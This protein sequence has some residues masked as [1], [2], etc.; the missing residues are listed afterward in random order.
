M[1]LIVKGLS[2]SIGKQE[3]FIDE[4]FG[5][6]D[7][8]KVGI[9]GRNGVGKTT[10]L[11][12]IMGNIDYNGT[13]TCQGRIAYFAQHID[14]DINLTVLEELNKGFDSKAIEEELKSIE[15]QMVDPKINENL[16]KITKITER[17]SEL[18]ARLQ[19][20]TE[21]KY[22][23][24]VQEVLKTLRID[25]SFARKKVSELS[26]GQKAILSLAK[27]FCSKCDILLLDE[28]TNH[29]D[30]ERLGILE[31]YISRFKGTILIITHDRFLLDKVADTILKI[32]NGHIIKFPGNY[33]AYV[34]QRKMLFEAQL[35]SFENEENYLRIQRDKIARIGKSPAKVKQ[36]QYRERLLE[37]REKIDKPDMDKSDFKV[38]FSSKEIKSPIVLT[39]KELTIGYTK[40][41]LEKI[42]LTI[43]LGNRIVIVGENGSGKTTLLKAIEGRI[44]PLSGEIIFAH[45]TQ[46]GYADQ[47]LKELN[48]ENTVYD[49][50][51]NECQ[52]LPT[53][54]ANLSMIGF[55]KDEE[56]EKKVSSL[57]MGE[58]SRLNLLKVLLHKPNFLLLDEPTNHLDIDAREII[59]EAF[60]NYNGAILAVSHDR[61]FIKKIADRIIKIENKTLKEMIRKNTFS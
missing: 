34:K 13:I 31:E 49:E 47:D 44:A 43:G 29:L 36:G 51:N 5:I 2:L 41:I 37:K 10:L 16:E 38:H 28:P 24:K 45:E 8:A 14:V 58:K 9:I 46:I 22:S 54:R 21:Y 18:Q 59:E 42:N 50:I 32:E 12:T 6:K 25:N 4:S 61:Y 33:S 55:R 26:T 11:K 60:L 30:F 53:T 1:D 27:I 7:G 52:D 39:L 17:Y 15:K 40:P 19:E 20:E 3:I 57:S 35:R 56:V 23:N 48:Y